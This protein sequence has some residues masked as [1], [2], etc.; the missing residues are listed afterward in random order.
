[1]KVAIVHDWFTEKGG[2]ENV[3]SSLL[4]LY[5]D[6][7]L[8]ALVDFFDDRQRRKVLQGKNVTTTFIARLPFARKIFRNYL[9]LFPLAI[10]RLD[11]R[12][13]DLVISSSYAV[14]K[15]VLTG[16]EQVHICYS[17][18]PMRYAWDMYFPYL[19]EHHVTGLKEK[20]LSYVL[21]K[22]RLW[23]VVSSNRVDW[24]IANSTLVQKRISKYYRRDSAVIHPP[25]DSSGFEL[26]ETK[27]DYFFTASRLVPY[28]KVRMIVEAFVKNGRRLI[29]AGSGPELEEIQRMATDN[30]TVLGY[31]SDEKMLKLMQNAKAFVFAAYEDFGIVPVEAMACGTPVI[32]YGRGGVLDSVIDG[33]TGL[34]FSEQ[35]TDSLN[36]AVEKFDGAVFD[37][38]A[39]AQ[40][41]KTFDTKLFEDRL[42]RFIDAKTEKLK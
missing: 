3:V 40:H 2:A 20:F 24:F 23:D 42:K 34:F 7:D 32:A 38:E 26:H 22:I 29:V 31:V 9:L 35:T 21:H 5:P 15:G 33:K 19:K 27:E 4:H 18:S 12:D 8:F 14:A 30:I 16:P 41:A 17:H 25:V 39:I 6:A 36:Q 1:M 11:L 37:C 28:K 13:Y 10:E